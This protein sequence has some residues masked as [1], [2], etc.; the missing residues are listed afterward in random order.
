VSTY[1][2]V[3][4]TLWRL[5][6][7]QFSRGD[8]GEELFTL[9]STYLRGQPPKSVNFYWRRFRVADIPLG[10]QEDFD[11]W[12]RE[13]WYEK[14]ALMDQYIATGRFPPS[15]SEAVTKGHQG[16]LETEVRARSRFEFLQIFIVLGVV[17]LLQNVLSKMWHR[18]THAIW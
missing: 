9:S 4:Q 6:I 10:N 8:F 7:Y 3:L 13:R 2:G 5:T 12:L 11:L 17:G 1:N 18:L 16:F 14:D 15:P